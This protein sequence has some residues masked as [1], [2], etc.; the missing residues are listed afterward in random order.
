MHGLTAV[1]THKTVMSGDVLMI[2][3]KT[4]YFT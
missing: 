2:M 3:C 4:C 1:A